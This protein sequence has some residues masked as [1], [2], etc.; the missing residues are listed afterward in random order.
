MAIYSLHHSA[1]GKT[2]HAAGTAGAHVRYVTRV[3]AAAAVLSARMPV[4]APGKADQ[5]RAWFDAEE[6]ASRKNARVADK[7]MLALPIELDAEQQVD[8]VRRFAEVATAGR[9]PWL[10]AIHAKGKDV[11]NPHCHLVIRDRDPTTGKRAVGLSEKGSTDRL[12]VLWEEHAN[13]ALAAAGSAARVDRRS[14][15][16]QG[17]EREPEIHV[18]PKPQAM[19]ARGVRPESRD[20]IDAGGREIRW[21]EIDAGRTRAER[22]AEIIAANAEGAQSKAAPPLGATKDDHVRAASPAEITP[23]KE[24]AAIPGPGSAPGEPRPAAAEGNCDGASGRG[25]DESRHRNDFG[26]AGAGDGRESRACDPRTNPDDPTPAG[27]AARTDRGEFEE[28]RRA[29]RG[30]G[31]RIE[32]AR[33]NSHRDIADLVALARQ[34]AEAAR[35]GPLGRLLRDLDQREAQARTRLAELKLPLDPP[36]ELV[37]AQDFVTRAA[38]RQSL[39]LDEKLKVTE[40]FEALIKS[41]PKG[42]WAWIAGSTRAHE[43]RVTEA[44]NACVRQAEAVR[45]ANMIHD[46]AEARV[47]HEEDS[48]RAKARRLDKARAEE[49]SRVEAHLAWI[50]AARVCLDKNPELAYA[51]PEHL[52]E[53]VRAAQHEREASGTILNFHRPGYRPK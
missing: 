20:L 48:W 16:D 1:I 50:A 5:T 49:R 3:R 44:Q 2:T 22:R 25:R 42:F 24:G 52:A 9:A 53:A 26:I 17:I 32:I 51:P 46:G 33:A 14:L 28:A 27:G 19:Q 45:L 10:A 18:G 7:L 23:P 31:A 37:A 47:R 13:A 15:A 8:L 6:T 41:R 34:I 39:L 11:K 21:T 36:A 40:R 38:E 43:E 29:A 12:R 30:L 4:A 35:L